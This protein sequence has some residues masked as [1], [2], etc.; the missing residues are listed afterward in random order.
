LEEDSLKKIAELRELLENRVRSL[1]TELEGMRTLLEFVNNLLLEQS[2]KRVEAKGIPPSPP[3]QPSTQPP[4]Q[5]VQI[6]AKDGE[7]LATVYK[8]VDSIRIVPSGNETF[9]M[10]TAP[11][12]PFLRERVLRKIR[13]RDQEAVQSGEISLDEAFSFEI[14]RDGDVIREITIRN[15]NR[16][17]ERELMSAIHWTLE[18]MHEKMES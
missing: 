6:K 12:V 4:K 13:E 10:T 1:E 2:F 17:R 11:F 3:A 16:E 5:T 15:V 8:E 7:V 18:K 14:K 9:T